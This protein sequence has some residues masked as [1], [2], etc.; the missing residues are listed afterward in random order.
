MYKCMNGVS[1]SYLSEK[2]KQAKNSN[3]SS[4]KSVEVRRDTPDYLREELGKD[5]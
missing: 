3:N 1:Q 4:V 2:F 5:K